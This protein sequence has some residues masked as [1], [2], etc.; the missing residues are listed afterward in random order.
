MADLRRVSGCPVYGG[1]APFAEAVA[2]IPKE[3]IIIFNVDVEDSDIKDCPVFKAP[4]HAERPVPFGSF[5]EIC[6]A[7]KPEDEKTQCIFNSTEPHS[8]TTGETRH[9]AKYVYYFV[10]S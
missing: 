1:K 4:L 3:K 2:K 8:G 5:D 9:L 10:L 6:T 7:L